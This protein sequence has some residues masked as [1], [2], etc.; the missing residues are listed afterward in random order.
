MP[1][2]I[3]YYKFTSLLMMFYT[4]QLSPFVNLAYKVIA[5]MLYWI[6]VLTVRGEQF[7]FGFS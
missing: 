2:L 4:W 7:Y 5:Y 1:Y 6:S 3:I